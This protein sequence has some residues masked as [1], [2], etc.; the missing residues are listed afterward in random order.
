[1]GLERVLGVWWGVFQEPVEVVGDV[2]FEAASCFA[3][4]FS[5]GGS[6]GDI[7]LGFGTVSG[8]GDGDVVERSVE[9]A[10]TASV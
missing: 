6:F 10:V 5:L 7:G 3:G 9:L 2:S 1:M 8:A 4:G